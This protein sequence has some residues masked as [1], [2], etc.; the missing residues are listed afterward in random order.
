MD[1][2]YD[3]ELK[4]KNNIDNKFHIIITKYILYK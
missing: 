2:S 1:I 3:Y 4:S